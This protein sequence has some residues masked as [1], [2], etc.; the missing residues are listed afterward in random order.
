MSNEEAELISRTTYRRMS[1]QKRVR[2]AQAVKITLLWLLYLVVLFLF[3]TMVELA[4]PYRI[5][6]KWIIIFSY[7]GVSVIGVRDM[8]KRIKKSPRNGNSSRGHR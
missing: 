3:I 7:F 8:E 2:A 5:I 6:L 4:L 1:R